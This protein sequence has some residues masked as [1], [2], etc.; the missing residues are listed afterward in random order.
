MTQLTSPTHSLTILNSADSLT[1][2]SLTHTFIDN[3]L[4]WYD[5]MTL[6]SPVTI[7]IGRVLC[8]HECVWPCVS[9]VSEWVEWSEWV[10]WVS[11]REWVIVSQW[12]SQWAV[13]WWVSEWRMC[14]SSVPVSVWVSEW[15][16]S[17]S[18]LEWVSEWVQWVTELTWYERWLCYHLLTCAVWKWY[19]L[20]TVHLLVLSQLIH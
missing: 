13:S 8:V 9:W 16:S 12:V 20:W 2:R 10:S 17:V 19:R 4:N 11:L 15:V 6:S 18:W 1:Q 5:T 14:V 7:T 3:T